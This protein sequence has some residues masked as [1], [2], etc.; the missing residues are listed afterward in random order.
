MTYHDLNISYYLE[1]EWTELQGGPVRSVLYP[2][3]L[4]IPLRVMRLLRIDY[5]FLV[6]NSCY[7]THAIIVTIG[8]YYLYKL[9]KLLFDRRAARICLL[10]SI[11][12][13][14]MLLYR[15]RCFTNTAEITFFFA[16]MYHFV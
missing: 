14:W 10:L 13:Y 12:N 9:A 8:D 4:S 6:R 16:A 15:P 5:N 7:I 2:A 11:F 3:L 1:W